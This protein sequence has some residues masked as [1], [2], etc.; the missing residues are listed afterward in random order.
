MNRLIVVLISIS[1]IIA[2]LFIGCG[3]RKPIEIHYGQDQCDYCK[4]I[5][6]DPAFGSEMITEKGKVYKF[7]S[8]ECLA[9]FSMVG[10][11]ASGDVHSMWVT[12]FELPKTFL[13]FDKAA[14]IATKRQKSPM[15]AGLVAVATPEQAARLIEVVGGTVLNWEQVCA[16]IAADWNL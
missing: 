13:K 9:A 6:V 12:N 16:K 15:G 4:M 11:V 10:G 5:I 14:I 3:R 2:S 8:I 7:D 1:I